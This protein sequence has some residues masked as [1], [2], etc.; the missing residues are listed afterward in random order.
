MARRDAILD[1]ALAAARV[2]DRLDIRRTVETSGGAI[3]VF[4]ALL[5]LDVAL[6]FRPLDGLLG[7]CLRGPNPGVIISTQRPLRIQRFTGAHELGHVALGHELSFDGEEILARA[8][9]TGR[10]E[11]EL[12]AD[13]FG[14]AFLLPKWLLQMHAKRQSWNKASMSDPGVVYQL[15]LRAGASYEATCI[16]LE[17][18]GIIDRV[19][20][21]RLVAKPRRDIKAELL[22]GFEVAD[23]H[24][25]V[26]CLTEHDEGLTLEGAPNDLFILKLTENGGAG[27]LW[28]TAGLVE[29]GF[30]ILRDQRHI[31]PPERAIG[32]PVTRE[33]TAQVLEPT[34]GDFALELKRPWQGS[35]PSIA[36]LHVTYDLFGKEIG[37]PRA[38]RRSYARAA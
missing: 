2:H 7:A 12:A 30:A 17:R 37:M 11:I 10:D 24:R 32:G 26:W 8:P 19:N 27:Y 4:G 15:A 34:S 29:A 21:E 5:A 14:A 9:T 18:H 25:D 36:S 22:D 1:G 35:G 33:L 28:T 6:L 13:S 38:V 31:P 3:D 23:F 16:A 20:R